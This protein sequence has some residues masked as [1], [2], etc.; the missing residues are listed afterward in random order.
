MSSDNLTKGQIQAIVDRALIEFGLE[1]EKQLSDLLGISQSD[2]TKRKN[3]GTIVRLIE[4]K[5]Y[6]ERKNVHFILTGEGE[7]HVKNQD[8]HATKR[9]EDVRVQELEE[10]VRQLESRIVLLERILS[11]SRPNPGRRFYDPLVAEKK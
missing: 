10:K 4:R 6:Q 7:M 9:S 5:A 1:N 2:K 11:Q 8:A 3:R